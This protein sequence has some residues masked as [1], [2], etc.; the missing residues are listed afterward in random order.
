MSTM[1]YELAKRAF[2]TKFSLTLEDGNAC[3]LHLVHVK[4]THDL[5]DFENK[6]R[7]HCFRL[8]FRSDAPLPQSDRLYTINHEE[9][10]SHELF[11]ST[12]GNGYIVMADFS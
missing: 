1:T 8:E 7:P 10:G 5:P 12:S 4:K 6:T 3:N 2:N 9:L 11:L